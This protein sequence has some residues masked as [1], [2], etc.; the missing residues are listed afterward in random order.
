MTPFN[1]VNALDDS[2]EPGYV[3]I[4]AP[5]KDQEANLIMAQR[6]GRCELLFRLSQ[7]RAGACWDYATTKAF[8]TRKSERSSRLENLLSASGGEMLVDMARSYA[9]A[10]LREAPNR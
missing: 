1:R 8:R 9:A 5:G 2:H 4:P 6:R 3:S 7:K 10:D